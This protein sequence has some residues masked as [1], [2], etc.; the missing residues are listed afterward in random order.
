MGRKLIIAIAVLSFGFAGATF[1]AV[2]NIKVSGDISTEAVTRDLFLGN[3]NDDSDRFAFSQVR[4]RLDADLTEGVSAVVRLLNERI[5][6]GNN[7]SYDDAESGYTAAVGTNVQLDLA[8]VELKEFMYDPLT[9][10]V[11]RQNLR[12]GNAL[13]IG[14]PDTNRRGSLSVV[15]PA[16]R[17]LTLRKSFDAV[18]GI[19]DFAPWTVD[20]ILAK[21]G[22][23]DLNQSDDTTI[24]GANAAYDWS[25]YNGVSEVYFF[26]VNKAPLTL[27]NIIDSN[28]KV[29]VL[30]GRAQADLND[31]L[32]LG[33]EVAWQFGDYR[34]SSTVHQHLNAYAFQIISEY[35]LLDDKNTKLGLNW[36]YLSGD[37]GDTGSGYQGWDPLFEDQTPSELINIY[38]PNTNMQ[39][40]KTSA[41]TMPREDITV[42]LDWTYARLVQDN[43]LTTMTDALA[44][45]N[46]SASGVGTI[47]LNTTKDKEI[48]HEIG[49]WGLYDYTEDVQLKLCGSWFIPGNIFADSNDST[50]YSIRGGI[51][52][53]F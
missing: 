49:L 34:A 31:N 15:A 36:T 53:G 8:Y 48:G 13:I 47:N 14:D 9:V 22:E 50:G 23:N 7:A 30:G 26:S 18:R 33:T 40:W 44:L 51:N 6:G 2:D 11:G 1:A 17:D 3:G 16:L 41:S 27:T 39:Y 38:F 37:N 4:V 42:G 10:L 19:L 24:Y 45:T 5:W 20:I 21:V 52:V 12:F 29:Y 43:A 35:R 32:T 25:S 28:N 46:T